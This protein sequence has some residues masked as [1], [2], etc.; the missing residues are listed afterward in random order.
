W[1]S[2]PSAMTKALA[3]RLVSELDAKVA[4]EIDD[5]QYANYDPSEYW[6]GIVVTQVDDF[7]QLPK[8]D[9]DKMIVWTKTAGDWRRM[10]SMLPDDLYV[11][12]DEGR[13][14]GL[15]MH[16][17][18]TKWNAIRLLAEKWSIDLS[19]IAAF[20]DDYNDIEMLQNCGVGVA[21]TNALDEVKAVA[22]YI[23]GS[24]DEDGVARWLE[25]NVL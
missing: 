19:K 11:L 17:N 12:K 13:S 2:I 20:G 3:G 23:C 9:A 21:V 8:I 10:E 7:N 1:E 15:I 25:E 22:N 16:K 5:K 18:A 24:N 6:P 14:T 4:V